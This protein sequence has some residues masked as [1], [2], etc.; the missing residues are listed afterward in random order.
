MPSTV[1]LYLGTDCKP[2]VCRITSCPDSRTPASAPD[3]SIAGTSHPRRV[4]TDR[5]G[6]ASLGLVPGAGG[7]WGRVGLGAVL[8]MAQF[9]A[10]TPVVRSRLGAQWWGVEVLQYALYVLGALLVLTRAV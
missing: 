10:A 3:G 7:G 2:V 9:V 8:L 4:P 6:V 5:I 1:S